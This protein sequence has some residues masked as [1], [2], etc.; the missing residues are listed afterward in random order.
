M[1]HFTNKPCMIIM[2]KKYRGVSV[3]H[4]IRELIENKRY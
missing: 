3:I 1:G 4:T 2:I